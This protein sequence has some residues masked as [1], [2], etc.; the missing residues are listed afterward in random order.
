MVSALGRT[1]KASARQAT[2]EMRR[3]VRQTIVD[4]CGVE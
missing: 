4:A 3:S 2:D 1:G